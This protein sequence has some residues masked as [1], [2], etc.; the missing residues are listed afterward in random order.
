MFIICP[1]LVERKS[2]FNFNYSADRSIA[3]VIEY[4]WKGTQK[5]HESNTYSSPPAYELGEE[6]ELFVNLEDPNQASVNTFTDRWLLI[7]IFDSIGT[8]FLLSQQAL[9]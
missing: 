4:E 7:I 3:P 8:V 2:C 5:Q 6:V 1:I 9:F